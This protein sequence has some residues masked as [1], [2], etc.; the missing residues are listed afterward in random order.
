M[1]N[2]VDIWQWLV[3][4]APVVVVMGVAIYYLA[5]KLTKAED[6]KDTLAK[7]VI[8]LTAIWEERLNDSKEADKEI[9]NVLLQIK[10]IVQKN[11]R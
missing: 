10:E 2:T 3:Q 11:N 6:D 5:K 7:D 4:Q 8:R 9:L 1:N